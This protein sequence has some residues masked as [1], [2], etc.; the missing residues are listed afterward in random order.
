MN[1]GQAAQL[2]TMKDV[3]AMTQI[4]ESTLRYYRNVGNK[5][6]ASALLGGKIMYRK[7]DV[8]KWINDQFEKEEKSHGH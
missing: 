4:S 8:E 6:P 5:G 3:S 2:L 7:Q 1:Q